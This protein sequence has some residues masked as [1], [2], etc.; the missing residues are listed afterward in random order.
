[1]RLAIYNLAAIGEHYKG[2]FPS[3]P[4]FP[5]IQAEQSISP[6]YKKPIL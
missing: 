3:Q 2:L 6:A 1:M 5:S 4:L